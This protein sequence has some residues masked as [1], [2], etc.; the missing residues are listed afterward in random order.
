MRDRRALAALV[1][2][3]TAASCAAPAATTPRDPATARW[4]VVGCSPAIDPPV[5]YADA[6]FAGPPAGPIA[7]RPPLLATVTLGEPVVAGALAPSQVARALH[8]RHAALQAC[9]ARAEAAF[10]DAD[11]SRVELGWRFAISPVGEVTDTDLPA[12]LLGPAATNCFAQLLRTVAFPAT[13]DGQP[14][15]VRIGLA[16]DWRVDPA[17]RARP[18][19]IGWTPF[20]ARRALAP[21]SVAAGTA[22]QLERILRTRGPALARCAARSTATGS[23]RAMIAL[24]LPG[25]AIAVR[26]GGLGDAAVEACIEGA[27]ADIR[28]PGPLSAPVEI[29]CDLARGD[30]QPWRVAPGRGLAT[31]EVSAAPAVTPDATSYLLVVGPD[32]RGPAFAA[33]LE[34]ALTADSVQVA[35]RTDPATAPRWLGAARTAIASAG[36]R[37]FGALA[38]AAVTL[39]DGELRTCAGHHAR[40][41]RPTHPAA[42]ASALSALAAHCRL[43]RCAATLQVAIAPGAYLRDLVEL[44]AAAR[45]AGFHRVLLGSLEPCPVRTPSASTAP[46]P[47]P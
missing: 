29:A 28:V 9:A 37:R 45:R 7:L 4:R 43:T 25:A 47:A 6:V 20:A 44:T 33:A 42:V 35:L 14:V 38:S 13:A 1:A 8:G 23:L 40:S 16:I 27:L 17:A 46:P 18:P 19:A 12:G 10:G 39:L 15:A 41:V 34:R 2:I 24:D 11:R 32:T 21:A 36:P 22:P 30:A 31:L 5:T 3:A 26:A